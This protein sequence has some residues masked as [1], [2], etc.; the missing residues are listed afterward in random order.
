MA[1]RYDPV[2]IELIDVL[3]N[4]S[5]AAQYAD[6]CAGSCGTRSDWEKAEEAEE[7]QHTARRTLVNYL[8][9]EDEG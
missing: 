4:K 9:L 6:S 8:N 7:E 1:K 2:T 5:R 3:I